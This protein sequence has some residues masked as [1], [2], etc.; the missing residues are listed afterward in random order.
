MT[1]LGA[2]GQPASGEAPAEQPEAPGP[3]DILRAS[4]IRA[5][6]A[7]TPAMATPALR[8]CMSVVDM[9]EQTLGITDAR[10]SHARRAIEAITGGI[11]M[12]APMP[13]TPRERVKSIEFVDSKDRSLAVVD[14]IIMMFFWHP[15]H[16][17]APAWMVLDLKDGSR[18][19]E[20][21]KIPDF[22][23]IKVPDSDG[24]S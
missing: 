2:D 17:V 24:E 1:V 12:G 18:L 4:I 20:E 8:A 6:D 13:R 7:A 11:V 5:A 14:P 3:F 10:L 21:I 16:H 23:R 22:E 9:I 15:D 19:R